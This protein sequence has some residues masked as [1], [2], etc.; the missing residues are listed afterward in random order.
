LKKKYY[1]GIGSR[2]IPQDIAD[3]M[4]ELG[5]RFAKMGF[6]LRSGASP[7]ADT[8]FELGATRGKGKYEIYLPW[9]NFGKRKGP[10]YINADNLDNKGQAEE[11]ASSFHPDFKNLGKEG[12]KLITRDTYQVM[13]KD[14]K[15]YSRFI[16]CWTPDGC[17]SQRYRTAETGGTGQAIGIANHL[18]IPIFNMGIDV[19]R[20]KIANWLNK[21]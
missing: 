12:K 11:I 2:N 14:L 15:T 20:E 21:S 1:A 13:G 6:I 16:V 18:M 9:E 7:G 5:Y 10:G 19:H 3:M 17:I 4:E 8:A